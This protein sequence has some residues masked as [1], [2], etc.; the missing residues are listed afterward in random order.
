VIVAALL[1]QSALADGDPASDYL[2]SQQVFLPFNAKVS[3]SAADELTGLL[4]ETKQKG[5]PLK[6]AVI[7][8]R[9]DLGAVPSLF[10]KPQSY[11]SFLGQE[12]YYFFKDELLVVMP[13]GYG[14]YKH[15]G[16]PAA[17]KAA[18]KALPAPGTNKGDPL[19]AAATRAVRVLAARHGLTL[20]DVG[21]KGTSSRTRDRIKIV[22]GVLALCALA[23]GVRV[24]VR[25]R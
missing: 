23:I 4:D 9:Y 8:S 10:G 1:V 22:A 5:F 24:L 14:L 18:I 20:A 21:S 13:N 7:S 2:I 16:V 25:R 6:V 17:D 3:T 11:A 12:D 15:A 19:V